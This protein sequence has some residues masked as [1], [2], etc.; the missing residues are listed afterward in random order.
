[1]GWTLGI[2]WE[3]EGPRK[4]KTEKK[5]NM[6]EV[7]KKKEEDRRRSREEENEKHGEEER[8]K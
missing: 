8:E 1:M 3:I 6:G 2:C 5:E 4:N 7:K